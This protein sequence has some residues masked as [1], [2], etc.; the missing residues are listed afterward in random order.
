[1]GNNETAEVN[2]INR[3]IFLGNQLKSLEKKFDVYLKFYYKR[4]EIGCNLDILSVRYNLKTDNFFDYWMYSFI[5]SDSESN[6][7]QFL[8][9]FARTFIITDML[10]RR[11]CLDH[12]CRFQ[13]RLFQDNVDEEIKSEQDKFKQKMIKTRIIFS[14]MKTW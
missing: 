11:V 13:N 8:E 3:S 5:I 9:D 2:I 10:L 12:E 14:T 1:M 6:E 7:G 4:R